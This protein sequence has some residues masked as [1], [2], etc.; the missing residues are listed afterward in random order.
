MAV[1]WNEPRIREVLEM[2]GSG[3]CSYSGLEEALCDAG[4]AVGAAES[5]GILCGILCTAGPVNCEAWIEHILGG[6]DAP[7]RAASQARPVLEGLCHDTLSHL[8][9]S[10]LTFELLLPDAGEPLVSRSMALVSW[11]QGFLFGL[12]LGGIGEAREL[13][14]DT[15]EILKDLY[16]IAGV[17][18]EGDTADEVEEGAYCEIVEYIRIAVLLIKEELPPRRAPS[19]LQ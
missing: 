2:K 18:F 5:H 8:N 16:E 9:D 17:R 3:Y 10:N 14:G 4:A 11:C 12:G 1:C 13:P 7:D 15:A 19:R 6:E